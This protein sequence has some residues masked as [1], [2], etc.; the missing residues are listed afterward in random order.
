MARQH[1]LGSI[2]TISPKPSRY[3]CLEQPANLNKEGVG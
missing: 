3:P 1:K 2:S